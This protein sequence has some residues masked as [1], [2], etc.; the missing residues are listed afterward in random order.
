[1]KVHLW[2]SANHHIFSWFNH[3]SRR[4]FDI[5]GIPV[6]WGAFDGTPSSIRPKI[7]VNSI[8]SICL[9]LESSYRFT[10]FASF[11]DDD[12]RHS[13]NG[14]SRVILYAIFIVIVIMMV[15]SFTISINRND[16]IS[17][18]AFVWIYFLLNIYLLIKCPDTEPDDRRT[19]AAHKKIHFQLFFSSSLFSF[20]CFLSVGIIFVFFLHLCSLLAAAMKIEIKYARRTLSTA[21]LVNERKKKYQNSCAISLNVLFVWSLII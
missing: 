11:V 12:R 13:S 5:I 20:S 4:T 17:F 2:T 10:F 1:M 19:R 18:C 16:G 21:L 7:K 14:D 15:Q 8:D 6:E 9:L 3:A